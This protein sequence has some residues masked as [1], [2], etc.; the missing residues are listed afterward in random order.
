MKVTEHWK[1]QVSRD[2]RCP[3]CGHVHPRK[4]VNGTF[5]VKT[6]YCRRDGKYLFS[7][8]GEPV[9]C[10][11]TGPLTE[12]DFEKGLPREGYYE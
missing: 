2:P 11:W 8:R 12:E 5:M 1:L 3:G 9:H 4:H 6:D 7:K 10:K